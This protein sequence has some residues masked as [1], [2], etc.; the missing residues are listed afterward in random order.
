MPAPRF[1]PKEV[2]EE[3]LYRIKTEGKSVAAISKD[4]AVSTKTVYRWLNTGVSKDTSILE[5]NRLRRERDELLKLV[6][7]LLAESKKG[8]KSRS[9]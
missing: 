9:G 1:W 4:Y 5:I 8:K 6:G 3:I 2:R 7:E